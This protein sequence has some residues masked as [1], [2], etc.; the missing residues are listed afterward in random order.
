VRSKFPSSAKVIVRPGWFPDTTKSL[1]D[2]RFAVVSL[3]ADLYQPIF[4][5][6]RF[7]WPKLS[8]GGFILVHDYNHQQFP[9]TNRA[10]K[11]FMR[12]AAIACCPVPDFGGTAVLGKPLLEFAT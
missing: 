1:D 4:E 6:L 10:V 12:E 3:D 9:G 8:P 11:D 7:F 2:T 5:G